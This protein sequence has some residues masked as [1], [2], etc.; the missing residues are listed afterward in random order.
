L[1]NVETSN[2]TVVTTRTSQQIIT[3]SA[4]ESRSLDKPQSS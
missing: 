3:I 1:S 4:P 2:T